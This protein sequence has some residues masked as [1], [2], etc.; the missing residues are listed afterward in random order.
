MSGSRA[1][2]P[3]AAV[4]LVLVPVLLAGC[5]SGSGRQPAAA[6]TVAP[7][8]GTEGSGTIKPVLRPINQLVWFAGFK[9]SLGSATL[10][11]AALGSRKVDVGVTLANQGAGPATLKAT[12]GLSSAGQHYQL[13]ALTTQ[14]PQVGGQATGTGLLSFDVDPAFSFSDAVLVI[15]RPAHQQSTVPLGSTGRLVDLAPVPLA[16]TGSVSSG[17]FKLDLGGGD[18]RSDSLTDYVEADVGQRF[19]DVTFNLSTT[20]SENFSSAN[21][22]LQMP[23]GSTAGPDDAATVILDPGPAK[24]NQTA[25]FTVKDPPSGRYALVLIDD[26]VKPP[27]RAALPFSVP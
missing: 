23:D 4:A 24:Q 10:H 9:I 7:S 6:T 17:V 8:A 19:L 22:A 11:Q 13:N 15:G 3:A 12:V 5:H 14:L 26:T 16:V 21:L 18:V 2:P 20:K 1:R 27:A 25:R